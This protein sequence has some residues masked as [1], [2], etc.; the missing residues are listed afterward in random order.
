[1]F[2]REKIFNV[3]EKPES[4]EPTDRVV[5]LREGFSLGACIFN[6]FWLAFNRMGWLLLGYVL[7]MIGLAMVA[8][9]LAFSEVQL[10]LVQLLVNLLLGFHVYDMAG[11]LLKRRGYR[12]AGVLVAESAMHAER[13]Y[14]EYAT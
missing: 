11:W 14:Y 7:V 2:N 10:L 8:Q 1:M 12:F 9:W 6:A 3:F 5:L 13:R 4:P